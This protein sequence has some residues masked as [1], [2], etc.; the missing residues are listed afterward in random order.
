MANVT[1]AAASADTPNATTNASLRSL[2][3]SSRQGS[4]FMRGMS[5]E[6]PQSEAARREERGGVTLDGL[7]LGARR[8]L[9]LSERV[10]FLR[11]DAD[12]ARNHVG[13]PRDIGAAAADHDL[14]GLL[15]PRA[16]G[17]VELQGAAHLLSHVIDKGV[18]DFGL[19]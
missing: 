2:R 14:L 12:A 4:R 6:T 13:H 17:Q 7:S 11:R 5:V 10:A 8:Q 19:V 18:E 9:H 3:C 15:T 1:R 16:G